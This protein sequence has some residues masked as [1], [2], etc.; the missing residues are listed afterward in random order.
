M[1]S[2]HK[3]DQAAQTWSVPFGILIWFLIDLKSGF[4]AGIAFAIG[5]QWLSPDLDTKSNALKRWGFLKWIWSPYRKL[6]PH[7]SLLSH[8]PFLGTALRLLYLLVIISFIPIIL[9]ILGISSP[10]IIGRKIIE[11]A[12]ERKQ[13]VIAA[14]LGLEASTW[15]H[16][17]QDGDPLPNSLRKTLKK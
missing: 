16:L 9:K 11:H 15:L 3:H 17:L 7:R 1:A 4:I 10:L 14:L 8:S 6:I 12:L 2:G 13:L 5:G